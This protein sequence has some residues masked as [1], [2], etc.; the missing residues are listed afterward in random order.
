MAM[1]SSQRRSVIVIDDDEDLATTND[2]NNSELELLSEGKQWFSTIFFPRPIVLDV[3]PWN[4]TDYSRCICQPAVQCNFLDEEEI[5]GD[6]L[7]YSEYIIRR[8]VLIGWIHL[9]LMK[10]PLTKETQKQ[11]HK[12]TQGAQRSTLPTQVFILPLQQLA[13]IAISRG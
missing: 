7:S 13:A 2:D 6:V 10:A 3:F 1:A 4:P 9:T 5:L 12:I 11:H 8:E